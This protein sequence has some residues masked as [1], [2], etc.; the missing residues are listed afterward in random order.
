MK[1]RHVACLSAVLVLLLLGG[2][3][4][5]GETTS[6]AGLAE[7]ATYDW[8]TEADVTV[9]LGSDEFAAV[10]DIENRS[11]LELYRSTRYGVDQPIP[12]RA[13]KF[14]HTNGTVVNASGID[15]SESRSRVTVDF[16]AE[17]GQFAFT[18]SKQS[19]QFSLPVFVQGSYEVVVPPDHRVDNFLLATVRPRGY[20]T[21]MVDDRVHVSWSELSSGSITVNYYLHR[22]LYLFA[23]L[24]V[25]AAIAGAIG[26]ARV[27]LQIKEL[28][29]RRKEL[30]LDL[31]V[32]E[33]DEFDSGPPPGMR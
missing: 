30:G 4:G 8:D 5:F 18:S 11:R 1:G 19:K 3:T 12:V 33:D 22:D 28:R 10:Y 13:V 17:H 25:V 6:E 23:G 31:D 14:R 16:P 21:T 29:E 32:D 24:V 2:C 9:D 15:V 20:E 27:W 7:N 26:M